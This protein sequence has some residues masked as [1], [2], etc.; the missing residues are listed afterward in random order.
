VAIRRDIHVGAADA[1]ADAVTRPI[2]DGGYR[3]MDPA[4]TIVGGPEQVAAQLRAL[5]AM[6]FT[7]VVIRHLADDQE[8]VLASF[9]RLAE[10][11]ALLAT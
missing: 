1:D 8:Q 10:V 3:G 5:A 6:G 11:R 7:D 4:A 2:L 9:G